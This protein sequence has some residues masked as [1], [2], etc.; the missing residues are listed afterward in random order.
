VHRQEN[1]IGTQ[2]GA[3]RMIAKEDQGTISLAQVSLYYQDT[4]PEEEL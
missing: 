1:G 2:N 4:R 3:T